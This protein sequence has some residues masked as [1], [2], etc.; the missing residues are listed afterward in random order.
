VLKRGTPDWNKPLRRTA[1][2]DAFDV[3]RDV[4]AHLALDDSGCL[5]W[6][7]ATFPDGRGKVRADTGSGSQVHVIVYVHFSGPVPD[8]L[9]VNHSCGRGHA[10]CADPRH[11]Y[12]G[13]QR[14]NLADAKRHGSQV[15][16]PRR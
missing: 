3:E 2:R 8:G 6:P 5:V 15:G 4:L 1:R 10:G 7:F 9:Q 12:A 14:E 11:L 13:T 16:R